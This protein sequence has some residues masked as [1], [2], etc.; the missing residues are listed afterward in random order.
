VGDKSDIW[1]QIECEALIDAD[2]F[3]ALR[4]IA[5]EEV[6]SAELGVHYVK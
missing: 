5:V 6:V 1:R 4:W 2:I 3:R